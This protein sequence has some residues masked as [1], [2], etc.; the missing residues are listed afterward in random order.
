MKALLFNIQKFSLHDGTGIRTSVFFQGCNLRCK[1][2]S[3]PESQ[4]IHPDPQHSSARAYT[5]EELVA[6]LQKDKVFYDTSGGGVT[7]TGGE[8]LLQSELVPALCGALHAHG[9]SVAVETAAHIPAATFEE[10]IP[11]FDLIHIDLKH[12]D[13][14]AHRQ[15]TGVGNALILQ[16]IRAAL[17]SGVRTIIR[18]PVIPGYNDSSEDMRGFEQ[19]LKILGAR[20]VHL[21]P[22]HQMGESKYQ[23]L[24]IQYDYMGLKQLHE[25]DLAAFEE[26]LLEAGLLVQIGG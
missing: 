1:W 7:L 19:L 16:N 22:F 10:M 26:V 17:S 3:N 9:I 25:E 12:Y 2:C 18:I 24:G 20:E 14:D 23:K 6:V 15:G 13:D 4:P 8:P 5:V 21:L 11:L